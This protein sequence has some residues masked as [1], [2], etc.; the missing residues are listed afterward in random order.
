MESCAA[1]LLLLTAW[2]AARNVCSSTS[3]NSVEKFNK[4]WE[5]VAVLQFLQNRESSNVTERHCGQ[6]FTIYNMLDGIAAVAGATCKNMARKRACN[7]DMPRKGGWRHPTRIQY[8]EWSKQALRFVVP[9]AKA[10]SYFG[11]SGQEGER[12]IANKA[13][14]KF[15][16]LKPTVEVVVTAAYAADATGVAVKL[17]FIDIIICNSWKTSLQVVRRTLETSEVK[18]ERQ[19]ASGPV[20]LAKAISYI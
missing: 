17:A 15:A 4:G 6:Q 5:T 11:F 7:N 16:R 20:L 19:P 3:R 13:L 12:L 2:E 9:N 1:F 8:T 14:E 18:F 10:R